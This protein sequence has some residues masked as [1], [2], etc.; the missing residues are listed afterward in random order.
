MT[1]SRGRGLAEIRQA[2]ANDEVCQPVIRDTAPRS[3]KENLLMQ[4]H[5]HPTVLR[6]YD[7]RGIIG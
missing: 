5:F 7:I 3:G 2:G 1:Q 4:H 6:E